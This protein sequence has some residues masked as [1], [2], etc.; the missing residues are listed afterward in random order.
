[1]R[2]F[3]S[4]IALLIVL[5][6]CFAFAACG[7]AENGVAGGEEAPTVPSSTPLPSP[8]PA[9]PTPS[10]K[11]SAAPEIDAPEASAEPTAT[12]VTPAEPSEA[13]VTPS[14]TPVP[15]PTPSVE[16]SPE[17]TPEA[18]VDEYVDLTAFYNNITGS[19]EF[20]MM[21]AMDAGLL[22]A[23]YPGLTGISMKQSICMMALITGVVCEIMLVECEN[24]EDAKTVEAIFEA[25][26]Q[27]QIDG[28]AFYP[29]SIEGW[30]RSYV[31]RH[32]S[33]VALIAHQNNSGDITA[34]F[35]RLFA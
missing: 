3:T 14:A 26:R 25:R 35:D 13:P 1:M 31:V 11:P 33:Y 32:G 18:P 22:D 4:L 16:T 10:S 15:T 24:E 34:M 12:P 19:F 17:P 6:M 27:S 21:G 8:T 2:T 7:K 20:A 28:G 23:F 9:A 30:E 29:E 5:S